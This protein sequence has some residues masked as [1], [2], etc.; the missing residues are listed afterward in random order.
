MLCRLCYVTSDNYRYCIFL[1]IHS[2]YCKKV[3]SGK[4]HQEKIQEFFMTA[5]EGNDVRKHKIK[6]NKIIYFL[7]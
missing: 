1:C 2:R 7:E 6:T 5:F 3:R 4:L